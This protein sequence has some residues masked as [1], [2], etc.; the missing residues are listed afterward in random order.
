MGWRGL[1]QQLGSWEANWT[2]LIRQRQDQQQV[3][4]CRWIYTTAFRGYSGYSLT[5]SDPRKYQYLYVIHIDYH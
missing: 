2:D 1:K 5:L 4:G 3:R